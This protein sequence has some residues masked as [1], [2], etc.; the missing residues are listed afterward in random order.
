M[1]LRLE[2]GQT[3]H[4]LPLTLNLYIKSEIA[5]KKEEIKSIARY[6]FRKKGKNQYIPSLRSQCLTMLFSFQINSSARKTKRKTWTSRLPRLCRCIHYMDV[7]HHV[8]QTENY[9]EI[10]FFFLSLVTSNCVETR[11]ERSWEEKNRSKLVKRDWQICASARIT[12][13]ETRQ[14]VNKKKM[15]YDSERAIEMWKECRVM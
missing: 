13:T 12:T 6:E 9:Y 15:V 7:V 4:K 2:N 11:A 5:L 3:S 10:Q 8:K 1:L 14:L